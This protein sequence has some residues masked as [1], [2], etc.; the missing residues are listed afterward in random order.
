VKELLDVGEALGIARSFLVWDARGPFG[1]WR[2]FNPL[3]AELKNGIWE[4]KAEYL[5]S[6]KKLTAIVKID[7]QSRRVIGFEVVGGQ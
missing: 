7:E 1:D 2:S 3:K 6:N 4:I 5:K